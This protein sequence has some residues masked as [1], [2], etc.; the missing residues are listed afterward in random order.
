MKSIHFKELLKA[1]GIILL[2]LVLVPTFVTIIFKIFIKDINNLSMAILVN[3]ISYFI[4]IVIIYLIYHKSLK[5]EWKRFIKNFKAYAKI[6]LQ[7]W[8]KGFLAMFLF[9]FLIILVYHN[10][11]ANEE[12]NRQL[13]EQLP[14]F[15]LISMIFLGPFFE[16]ITFRKGFKKAFD[17]PKTFLIVTSLLFGG[18]HL[19]TSFDLHSFDAF[20]KSLPQLLYIFSYGSLGYFFGKAYYETDCIFTSILAHVLHNG[21]T[22]FILL[23]S[24][25][26][27]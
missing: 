14:I 6:A 24:A 5:E 26:L 13:L 12:S 25:S 2:Y 21:L 15:S 22:V 23:L 10:M 3:L 16:E 20:V 17:N 8:A 11:A 18:A 7:N 4:D 19:I 1:F 27:L 9:N